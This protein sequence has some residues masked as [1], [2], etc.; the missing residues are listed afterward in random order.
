MVVA[1]VPSAPG[2][3]LKVM[4]QQFHVATGLIPVPWLLLVLEVL[5]LEYDQ[6]LMEDPVN[7]SFL[8]QMKG[9]RV[10]YK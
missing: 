1:G 5:I 3:G 2:G 6:R 7:Q 10:T 8:L 9:G 4:G